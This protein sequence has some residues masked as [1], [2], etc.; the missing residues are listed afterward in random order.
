MAR[1]RI[2][3]GARAGLAVGAV[4]LSLLA[5]VT[6]SATAGTS[7]LGYSRASNQA[8]QSQPLPGS[9]HAI[10]SR[11]YSRP[12]PRCT[13]GALNPRVTQ[14]TIR[15]TICMRG[16]TSTVRPPERITEQEKAA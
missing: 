16:W 7:G 5:V 9:C 4:V 3:L 11:L 1:S 15:R 13:P 12:D 8:V 10:G 6:I 2:R 14:A